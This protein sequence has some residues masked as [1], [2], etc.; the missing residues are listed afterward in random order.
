MIDEEMGR[1]FN[2]R[3]YTIVRS[4][5]DRPMAEFM[6]G[7][8]VNYVA[9]GK[10][11]TDDL[12]PGVPSVYGDALMEKMLVQLL[13]TVEAISGRNVYPTYSFFRVYR[14][15]DTLRRHIDRP[16]CEFSL[17]VC[18]G[19][20]AAAPWPLLIEGPVGNFAAELGVGDGVLYK[21]VEC[22]HWREAFDGEISAQAFFHYVDRD[23][24]YAE[25]RFD[26]R[27]S[28]GQV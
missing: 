4:I 7:Y 23:G 18:L 1:E 12:V 19:Y 5:I 28:T 11:G 22:P 20:R 2:T 3:K 9:T 15:G 13:P 8:A 21:G 24:P 16:S 27:V 6:N 14:A 26:K 10:A 25:W 17:S